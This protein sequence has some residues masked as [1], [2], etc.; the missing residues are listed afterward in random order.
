[1][2]EVISL[3]FQGCKLARDLE[4]NLPNF[5]NQPNILLKTCEEI[6][7]IFS[8]ARDRLNAHNYPSS[9][10]TSHM[11]MFRGA[12]Q[13]SHEIGAGMQEW[14]RYSCTQAMEMLHAQILGG[15]SGVEQR[16]GPGPGL[17]FQVREVAGRDGG[18]GMQLRGSGGEVQ[19]P[20]ILGV[21]ESGRGSSSQQRTRRRNDE[22]DRWTEMV[23]APQV[24][25]IEI[26]PDDHYTWRK[27]GQKEI[28][29]SRFPRSYYRC[30]HQKLYQCPAKKQVQ[31]LDVDPSTFEVTYR[32]NHTCHMSS[33]A[34][35]I[36]P[37]PPPSLGLTQEMMIQST[38]AAQ[39]SPPSTSIPLARW[40]SMDIK[41]TGENTPMQLYGDHFGPSGVGTS[42]GM[43]GSGSGA[44]PSTV[45][46]GVDFQPVADMADVMFNSGSSSSNSMDH[47]FSSMEEKWDTTD[48]KN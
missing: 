45:R 40:L 39:P 38:T 37:H 30:T 4:S 17:E 42:S 14:L 3:V 31:R 11:M 44:G 36:P 1:M 6:I 18:G 5:A 10:S 20:P 9:S 21:S 16:G 19:A 32:G 22:V 33:T 8:A 43:V 34:P 24:G 12:G 26:P 23:S 7:T 46:F 35:S 47:I 48:K 28:L 13:E 25:N 27:Y 41:P 29:G 15:N 2:E